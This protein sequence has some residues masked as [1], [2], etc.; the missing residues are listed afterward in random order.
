MT[1]RHAH[2]LV[3]PT[4][5]LVLAACG[6]GTEIDQ[7]GPRPPLSDRQESLVPAMKIASPANCVDAI[8][9]SERW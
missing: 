1:R 5:T 2:S 8:V 4:I 9:A 3:A 7:T 6:S